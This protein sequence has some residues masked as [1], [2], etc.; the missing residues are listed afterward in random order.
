MDR[1]ADG[2]AHIVDQ[3]LGLQ[4]FDQANAVLFV[5]AVR[6][7]VVRL[8]AHADDMVVAYGL[9]HRRQR[10]D[11][12]AGAIGEVAAVGVSAAVA[13]RAEEL[14]EEM[15]LVCMQLHPIR[16]TGSRP[17]GRPTATGNEVLKIL[18]R[19][20]VHMLRRQHGRID[21]AR[22]RARNR[23]GRHR[24]AEFGQMHLGAAGTEL[25]DELGAVAV[26]GLRKRA[27]GGDK[28]IVKILEVGRV[29]AFSNRGCAQRN[30]RDAA[31][32][33]LLEVGPAAVVGHAV[34]VH[35]RRHMAGTAY[36][37]TQ[38][39]SLDRQ[40]R[41]DMRVICHWSVGVVLA[42]GCHEIVVFRLLARHSR[43]DIAVIH[44]KPSAGGI[45]C[46]ASSRKL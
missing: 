21:N 5:I 11:E 41:K 30:Q 28:T 33:A 9:P 46:H 24:L 20:G 35:P 19:P 44:C 38:R 13:G 6:V 26:Y 4:K 25:G 8:Q 22:H 42:Y 43:R 12:Q 37:V 16:A 45:Q 17:P 34:V 29:I 18:R 36:A 14:R 27:V 23:R 40:R 31:F 39:H 3:S 10:L 32:G 2:E 7:H 1:P 15:M